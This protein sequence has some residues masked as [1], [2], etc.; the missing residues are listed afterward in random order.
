M[1]STPAG[2][3]TFDRIVMNP[4]F[5]RD[6]DA[7]HVNHAFSFLKPGGKLVA[8]VGSYALNGKTEERRQLQDLIRQHGRLVKS[9][10][11][12]R[13]ITMHGQQLLS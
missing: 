10:R 9:C 1:D 11:P 13:L 5:S 6:Q 3:G 12:A 2:F 7:R 8:I 4:P